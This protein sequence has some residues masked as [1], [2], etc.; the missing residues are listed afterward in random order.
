MKHPAYTPLIGVA[1][2]ILGI[3]LFPIVAAI[4]LAFSIIGGMFKE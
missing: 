2:V 1:L 4:I 3:A